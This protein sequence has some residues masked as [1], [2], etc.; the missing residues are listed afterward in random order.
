MLTQVHARIHI[1]AHTRTHAYTT[2]TTLTYTTRTQQVHNNH[3]A[4]LPHV[5]YMLLTQ[6]HT[7]TTHHTPYTQTRAHTRTH[8]QMQLTGYETNSS[9]RCLSAAAP[10]LGPRPTYHWCDAMC[11]ACVTCWTPAYCVA[12]CNNVLCI[13]NVLDTYLLRCKLQCAEHVQ[14]VGHL[15]TAFQVA[16]MC[17]ACALC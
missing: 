11:W 3:T 7:H 16:I 9:A 1:H 10:C 15:P 2:H 6:I 14:C 4:W 5:H 12:S 13:C 17:C 8:T